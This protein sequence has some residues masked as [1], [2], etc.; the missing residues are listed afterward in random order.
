MRPRTLTI[1]RLATSILVLAAGSIAIAQTKSADSSGA[2]TFEQ[3][4]TAT[5]KVEAIDLAKREVTLKGPLGNVE[6]VVV[7]E[8]VKR[9][10]EV[11]VGDEV[12]VEYYIGIAAELRAPTDEEMKQPFVVL[13]GAAK[14][15]TTSAPAGATAR[16][17]RVVAT[18]EGLDRPTQTVTL[19]GPRGRYITVRVE[20]PGVLLKPR[21]GD[22]VVVTA[23]EALAVSLEKAK[24]AAKKD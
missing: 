6:T 21:I 13:D 19:K 11:K 9:L 10:N 23:A 8:D 5:A 2:R 4:V 16:V 7:G 18:V 20:D 24:P 22:K 1:S 3:L 15:P 17:V 14:A 12:T